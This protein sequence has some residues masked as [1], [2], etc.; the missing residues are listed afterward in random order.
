MGWC[1]P[2][3]NFVVLILVLVDLCES[4]RGS[5]VKEKGESVLQIYGIITLKAIRRFV[6]CVARHSD[7]LLFL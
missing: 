3:R 6:R 4:V 2:G 5:V 7:E 1:F